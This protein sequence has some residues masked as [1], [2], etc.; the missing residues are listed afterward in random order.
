MECSADIHSVAPLALIGCSIA[1]T[2]RALFSMQTSTSRRRGQTK[3]WA[4]WRGRDDDR[5]GSDSRPRQHTW[6]NVKGKAGSLTLTL[7]MAL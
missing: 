5:L 2:R 7:S 6:S 3:G 4:G 1:T